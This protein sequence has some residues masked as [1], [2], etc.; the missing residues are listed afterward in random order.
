MIFSMHE[1]TGSKA[2]DDSA[3]HRGLGYRPARNI[4]SGRVLLHSCREQFF[5]GRKHAP[6]RHSL[7][8]AYEWLCR[9]QDVTGDGGV[10]AW[11]HLF[12]GWAASYPETTGYIIPTFLAYASALPEPRAKARAIRMADFETTV[13]L[14]SGAVRS[15]LM[16]MK[17]AP[18]VFNT[19][20]VL[21]GW[22][23]AYQ[24]T[25][26]QR[27]SDAA[28]RAA[29]WL[30]CT[31]DDD[32]A[33]RKDLSPLTTST[34][35]TYN[36]RS[37]WGLAL[38]GQVLD[39]PRWI[40]AARKNC[41]W[42]LLQQK[43]NG[44]FSHNSFRENESPL[45]HTIGYALEGL[46]GIGELLEAEKYI[47]AAKVGL[48]PLVRMFLKSKTLKGRYGQDWCATVNWRC[49]T[50]EAQIAL[51]TARLSER[52]GDA[53]LADV[54][55]EILDGL[56]AVQD[57]A[58]ARPESHGALSGSAPLWG[59]YCPFKLVNWAAKFYMDAVLLHLFRSDV[60]K[61]CSWL[62]L[63]PGPD[64]RIK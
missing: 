36:V 28:K 15:G 53:S 47:E 7:Q 48:A 50:G 37:A 22:I 25:R 39:E 34:V 5:G 24:V 9:A 12:R 40:K 23:A 30:T 51:V 62:G 14:P 43:Q 41:D 54:T 44:W 38:A 46:L 63:E 19:G 29:T 21:F 35:Q 64:H 45:L 60:Q 49:L 1:R 18:A 20:Q 42:A 11:Y 58:S 2:F 56:S 31:Q 17:T 26:D 6:L 27:Y 10:A 57:T 4:P 61:P 8:A 16:T 52:L 55:G 13:Q 33:W 3:L 32:G 59:M